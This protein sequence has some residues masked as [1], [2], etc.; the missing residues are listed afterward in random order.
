MMR[1]FVVAG[2]LC[3]RLGA[4]EI[5]PADKVIWASAVMDPGTR[6]FTSK[7]ASS[8]AAQK[9]MVMSNVEYLLND[10]PAT[11]FASEGIPAFDDEFPAPE[12][13]AVYSSYWNLTDGIQR[14]PVLLV[15]DM[16]IDYS[17][18]VAYVVP[19][20]LALLEAFRARDW[21]VIWTNWVRKADDGYYSS[22]DRFYG[23]KGI[24]NEENP[25]YTYGSAG[26]TTLSVLRPQ[27]DDE[28]SRTIKSLHLSKFA[29]MHATG[30]F[31]LYP[32]LK[33]WGV[34]TVII[35]RRHRHDRK[36]KRSQSR[37]RRHRRS[38]KHL[39]TLR[40]HTSRHISRASATLQAKKPCWT[41]RI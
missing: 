26:S 28:L 33:K 24:L 32:K 13:L 30:N 23:P 21:P 25:M 22:L 6:D 41:L 7:F 1:V 35:V 5:E 36:R 27:N 16:E 39:R 34:D 8:L 31:L 19:H 18:D 17:D 9:H 14:R 11:V 29:D 2:L 3:G 4:Y 15:E 38:H 40:C 20:T 10:F 37:Q 12:L